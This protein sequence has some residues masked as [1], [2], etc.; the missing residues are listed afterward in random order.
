MT[1]DN[2]INGDRLWQSLMEMARIGALPGGGCGRLA[3]TDDDQIARD[4]FARWC[5]EAGCTVTFDRLGNM[6]ARR[7]GRNPDLPPIAIGSHLD[8]QPH[9]GRFDG[10]YGVMAGLEIVR[11]L[12]DLGIDTDAPIEIVNWTNEEG[13]RF[14]PAMLCSGVYAGL[15]DLEFA[16][17]RTDADGT[18]LEDE[19]TR[20]GYVGT[21]PCGAHEMGA[22]LE[23]HI[24]QGPVLERNDE[25]IGV[26]TGGQGQRWYDVT[27]TGRDA[28]SGSTPMQGRS[29]ALIAAARMITAVQEIA[30]AHGP[31]GV[32][33]VGELHVSPNSRN[34]IPGD[35]RFTIDFRHPDDA[36]LSVMDTAITETA[37][38][39]A[40]ARVDLEMI[41]HNPPVRFDRR[42]VDAIETATKGLD[43]PFRRMVSGAGHDAC[44][45]ARKVPTAMVFVPCR[46]GLSHNEAEWA[47]PAHLAAGCNVLFRAALAL[48]QYSTFA[49]GPDA[50]DGNN[51]KKIQPTVQEIQQ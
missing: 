38:A 17:S 42:C 9:G 49:P 15:F 3:L 28:H 4:L 32:G 39:E 14:A 22:F 31:D 40:D 34:T 7:E 23:A 13:A 29:D 35:V 36:V 51:K 12:N 24:E 44:L 47:E 30:L 10:V 50:E 43:Y 48:S 1:D 8:T 41:W 5:E 18:R 16:L 20:I 27:V 6:F 37:K 25:I 2:Q 21:N 11:S 19:L 26:V 45:V 46:D 33:T